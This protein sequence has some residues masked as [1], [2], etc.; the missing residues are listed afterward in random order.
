MLTRILKRYEAGV[1]LVAV[2]LI[3]L[4]TLSD[5]GVYLERSLFL[6][7]YFRFVSAIGLGP[8]VDPS[9][10]LVML[11]DRSQYV[12]GRQ[13]TFA[14]WRQVASVLSEMGYERILYAGVSQLNEEVGTF[15][16]ASNP[17]SF[18]AAGAT[19]Y[20]ESLTYMYVPP[21]ATEPLGDKALSSAG[22][23][24]YLELKM[25]LGS[26]PEIASKVDALGH[27][28]L[29]GDQ[30]VPIAYRFGQEV[31][32]YLGLQALK[33]LKYASGGLVED[34]GALPRP[35]DN[36]LY[37][38]YPKVTDV[39][40]RAVPVSAFFTKVTHKVSN[41]L[42][43]GNLEALRGGRVA[44]LIPSASTG[45]RHVITPFGGYPA[46]VALVAITS[47]ALQR[48]LLYAPLAQKPLVLL[49]GLMALLS[50]VTM[51]LRPALLAA[52]GTLFL[53]AVVPTVLLFMKGW[54][55]PTLG[56]S[57]MVLAVSGTRLGY[58]FAATWKEKTLASRDLEMGRTIQAL[59]LP[60]TREASVGEWSYRIV[61][62]PY[63][64]MSG[65]W[66]QTYHVK[67]PTQ[68]LRAVVA[69]GDVVGKGPSAALN[70]ATITSVWKRH[71][72]EFEKSP[73]DLTPF[74]VE[75]DRAIEESYRGE[76]TTSIQLAAIYRDRIRVISCGAPVWMKVAADGV[77]TRLRNKP[78]NPLGLPIGTPKFQ[79]VEFS[80]AEGDFFVAHTD[81]VMEGSDSF[82]R[83]AGTVKAAAAETRSFATIAGAARAAGQGFVIPDDFTML[84]IQRLDKRTEHALPHQ[85]VG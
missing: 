60:Q 65:D 62:E 20:R 23:A 70:T 24:S 15:D 61:F 67:D 27:L 6:T 81:G 64:P 38:D 77:S 50:T 13:P 51:R 45:G 57:S 37:V 53:T 66:Y 54:I 59:L 21:H 10:R 72:L 32:P 41:Q 82:S 8:K 7:S 42:S 52:G 30:S 85:N 49:A 1:T 4:L 22:K 39:L 68:A 73:D 9:L 76:Q 17:K 5:A 11:D 71:E 2:A 3:L 78:C 74:L 63:G 55:F 36:E 69:I 19:G 48:H 33:G 75:L 29:A 34:R 46:Y 44:L 58:F 14:E 26:R 25:V 35:A 18:F 80:V 12:L 40:S 43:A 84:M 79:M 83:F 47:S 16:G 31:L 56:M 28:N